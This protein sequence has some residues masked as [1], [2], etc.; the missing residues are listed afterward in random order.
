MKCL[1]FLL[2]AAVSAWG[3]PFSFGLKGGGSAGEGLDPSA[4]ASWEGKQYVLGI[5]AET[6]LPWRLAAEADALYRRTG[7]REGSC[8]FTLC[9]ASSLRANIFE[10]PALLRYRLAGRAVAP[11]VSGGV[12]YR[13]V[14]HGTG[15]L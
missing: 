4:L 3:Q 7:Q 2:A 9:S 8:F 12:A 11:F 5:M 13:W 6:R 1:P 10:F 14:R 15:S